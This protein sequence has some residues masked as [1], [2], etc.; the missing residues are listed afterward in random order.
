MGGTLEVNF[1]EYHNVATNL[2]GESS[3]AS[4]ALEYV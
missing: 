2:L 4:F 3:G 1:H